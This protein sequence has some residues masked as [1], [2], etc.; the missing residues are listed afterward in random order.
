VNTSIFHLL[1][2]RTSLHV[3]D[4][5]PSLDPGPASGP[6]SPSREPAYS[7][8][9]EAPALA[10]LDSSRQ[11]PGELVTRTD[12]HSLVIKT[13]DRDLQIKVLFLCALE[14][15]TSKKEE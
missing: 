15:N 8:G 2:Q 14:K 1:R 9:R 10:E 13:C 7:N 5:P 6:I 4:L 12:R 11:L 3:N